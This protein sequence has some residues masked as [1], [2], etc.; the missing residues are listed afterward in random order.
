[1]LFGILAAS[2]LLGTTATASPVLVRGDIIEQR[3]IE[4]KPTDPD[5]VM[6]GGP[7]RV[8]VRVRKTL[9]GTLPPRTRHIETTIPMASQA[10]T[11]RGRDIYLLVEREGAGWRGVH[12]ETAR[13]G[14]CIP[15]DYA[16]KQRIEVRVNALKKQGI[17]D[18][19]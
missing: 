13:D 19:S 4:T 6:I 9:I 12:W 7:T 1:M 14:I 8:R 17:V 5:I 16:R 11:R 15:D 18:C 2:A 10:A 3:Y